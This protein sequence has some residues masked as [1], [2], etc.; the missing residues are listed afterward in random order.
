MPIRIVK[1][2]SPG[3]RN[4]SID[5][6]SDITKTEPEKALVVKLPRHAGR[7]V[8][9]R[10]TVRHRVG[11]AKRYYRLVDFKQDKFDIPAE[12]LAI[13]YDPYRSAR[14][15]LV[16]YSDG[17]KRYLLAFNGIKVGDQIISSRSAVPP[18]IGN[19][20]PLKFIPIG[21]PIFNIELKPNTKGVLARGA[22]GVAKFMAIEGGF[23]QIKIPSG[24]VRKIPE[25]CA[26]TIG[27]V[28]NPDWRLITWGKA[29]R[30]FHRGRR[31]TVRGKAMNPVD[32]PHG[33]GE[34]VSPIGLKHP[35]TP[36][37]KPALGVKTRKA[38][39]WSNA[40]IVKRRK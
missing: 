5:A 25:D 24:E 22:G 35:K 27:Q 40:L 14:I 15:A 3:R 33:G 23:A 38:N 17:E 4:L 26:A 9:G 34:G 11:G 1:P 28:S 10:I 39:K 32:H 2:T 36:W 12:V 6:F 20:M 18:K 29:G 8:A 31:P 30:M 21:Q 19:R 16:K 13:E 7:N 37:G